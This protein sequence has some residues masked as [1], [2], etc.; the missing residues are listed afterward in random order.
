MTVLTTVGTSG[1]EFILAVAIL[2]VGSVLIVPI[3]IR[4]GMFAVSYAKNL[5][6][7]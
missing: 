4:L 5:I 2:V 6:R 7:F 1:V 3:G